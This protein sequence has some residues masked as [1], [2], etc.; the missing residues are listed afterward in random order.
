MKFL[1]K[2]ESK[3]LTKQE[4]KH[5]FAGHNC[6]RHADESGGGAFASATAYCGGHSVTCK[7]T[8]N[9]TATDYVGCSCDDGKD[10]Q[11]CIVL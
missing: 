3:L 5:I 8:F 1:N 11:T 6:L 7:G 9:C 2:I 10:E 4:M